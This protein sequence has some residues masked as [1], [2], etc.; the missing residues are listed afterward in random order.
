MASH[1][2]SILARYAEL[3]GRIGISAGEHSGVL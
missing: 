2:E 3:L 1:R